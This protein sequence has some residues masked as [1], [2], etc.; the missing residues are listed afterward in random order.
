MNA[1]ILGQIN[2]L[3]FFQVD[4]S[5]IKI[6]KKSIKLAL[7]LMKWIFIIYKLTLLFTS[8]IYH[9]PNIIVTIYQEDSQFIIYKCEEIM[10]IYYK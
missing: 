9:Y 10:K 1:M 7:K 8:W 2:V 3:I 5:F 6:M 4:L